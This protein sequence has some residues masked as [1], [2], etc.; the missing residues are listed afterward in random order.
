[1]P[2]G[3]TVRIA[4]WTVVASSRGEVLDLIDKHEDTTAFDRA[5]T[6]AWTQA[7]VQL[8][9]LGIDAEQ[10]GLFQRLAGH[11]LYADPSLRP[12]SDTIRRGGG[13]PAALWV[14]GISGD[15]PIVL[16]R[17]D[18]IEDI[19]IVR[20]LLRAHE[21]WRMKQLAVDLVILNDRA[22]SYIQD[23]QIALETQVRT[24][25]SRLQTAAD[26]ARGAVFVLRADLISVETRALLLSLARAV[27][28]GRRGTLSEQLNRL[29]AADT[30]AAAAAEARAA[31][32]CVA[33][34][35]GAAG[36]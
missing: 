3:R 5:A 35:S 6:L 30:A 7:Q 1:V 19:A 27:L 23:L 25:Q 13:G 24:S 12:S 14:Q 9:Y 2:P 20:Q 21:Y 32:G 33:D 31:R 22:P 26:V 8:S 28:V 18:N 11:V 10:A 29:Q 15:L 34:R 16:A 36:S 17:I 4:F